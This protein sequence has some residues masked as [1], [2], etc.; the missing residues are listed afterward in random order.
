M[1]TSSPTGAETSTV[2]NHV[3][4]QAR[5]FRWFAASLSVEDIVRLVRLLEEARAIPDERRAAQSGP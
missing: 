5:P 2:S 1:D 3:V 4:P